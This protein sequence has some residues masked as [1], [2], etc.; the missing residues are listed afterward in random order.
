MEPREYVE[1]RTKRYMAQAL[2]EFEERLEV[3]LRAHLDGDTSPGA[4]AVLAGV[5][6]AKRAFRKKIQALGAD[7]RDVMPKDVQI[8]G[9]EPLTTRS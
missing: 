2:E 6:P 1:T 9:Y 4:R 5:E 3:P 8:N 7:C